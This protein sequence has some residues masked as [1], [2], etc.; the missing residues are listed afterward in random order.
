MKSVLTVWSVLGFILTGLGLA[1][2]IQ[3]FNAIELASLPELALTGY[4]EFRDYFYGVSFDWW[5]PIEISASTKDLICL[6]IFF[7]ASVYG[8]Y[9]LIGAFEDWGWNQKITVVALA[10]V[11]VLFS[12]LALIFPISQRS[13]S[14]ALN[15]VRKS[16]SA[17][18]LTHR[19]QR[20]F[21]D[22]AEAVWLLQSG[23]LAVVLYVLF[24]GLMAWAFFIWIR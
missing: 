10:P 17:S 22:S 2:T 15:S 1:S 21:L 24:S 3:S 16:S 18:S 20:T 6:Y 11:I 7:S 5:V 9:R 19:N 14:E 8:F 13:L 4:R 23:H 12:F